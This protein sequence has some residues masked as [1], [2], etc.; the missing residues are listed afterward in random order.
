M[1]FLYW[2]VWNT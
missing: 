1:V 2:F